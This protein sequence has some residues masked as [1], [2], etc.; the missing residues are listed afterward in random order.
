MPCSSEYSPD[1]GTV[2]PPRRERTSDASGAPV[3]EGLGPF[4]AAV[5]RSG[6]VP[7]ALVDDRAAFVVRHLQQSGHEAY[8]VGGC[9]RDLLA[10]LEPKD[11]DVATD[12]WPNRIKRL[13]RSARVIG[14]RFRLVH[15]RFPGDHVIETS[16]FRA[17]PSL[18][19]R[20]DAPDDDTDDAV[21]DEGSR[22]GRRRS[23]RDSEENVFGTA[24]EDARRRDFTI[25]ALYYDPVG[26]RV[27]DHVGGLADMDE[28]LIRCIG[29]PVERIA[30]DPVRM[31]RAVHFAERMG[32]RIED[33][34]ETAIASEAERLVE[35]S[36]ARLYVELV[37]LLGRSRARPTFQRL[38]RLGLLKVWLPE[39]ASAL[40][41]EAPWPSQEGGTHEEASR[42]EPE[43][44]PVGHATWNLLGAADTWGLAA[45]DAPESLALAVLFGP[46]LLEAWRHTSGV[47][48]HAHFTEHVDELFGPIQ[49][50]MSIPRWAAS[51][52]RDVIWLLEDLRHPPTK[53]RRLRTL[54]ARRAFPVALELFRL[55]LMARDADM[56]AHDEWVEQAKA[57]RVDLSRAS[58]SEAR[59]AARGD[60]SGGRSRGGRSGRRGGRGRGRGGRS[61]EGGASSRDGGQRGGGDASPQDGGSSRRGRKRGGRG[62]RRGGSTPG[63]APE[64][65]AFTPPPR[66]QDP[67]GADA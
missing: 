24:P 37:K 64:A 31:L 16:T 65:D 12:A 27:I 7:R 56:A 9:V 10:G 34:L 41:V 63:W 22:D 48:D 6:L 13:F 35:A 62:R 43:H 33:T 61:Q 3:A 11:F 58:A 15:I 66:R 8:L 46:W 32:F 45:H 17:D 2:P 20:D 50:R 26:D 52:M 28:G 23:W 51:E 55:D 19:A 36:H 30:E 42:G 38:Q 1:D 60:R 4:P 47:R 57:A 25:N 21:E 40:D 59:A 53:P 14:R 39:L 49:R 67:G 5:E 44:L 29:E 54:L 18:R